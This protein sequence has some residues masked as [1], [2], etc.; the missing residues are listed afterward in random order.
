MAFAAGRRKRE[1]GLERVGATSLA[2][3]ASLLFYLARRELARRYAGSLLGPAWA[4]VFP[5]LQIALYWAVFRY[6]LRVETQGSVP[7]GPM[8][9]A[10]IVPWLA[11]SEALTTM[12]ASLKANASLVKRT[13]LPVE[14]LPLASLAAAACVHGAVLLLAACAL[15]LLGFAPGGHLLILVY[16]AP[17]V[18]LL[19]LSLGTLLALANVAFSD[20]AQA[21]A[22]ILLLWF[23]ATPIL[24]QTQMLPP[25]WRWLASANPLT[26]PVEL[27]RYALLGPRAG[28]P[29]FTSALSFWCFAALLAAAAW[30]A[31]RRFKREVADLL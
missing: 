31:L 14:L 4:L 12:T 13:A 16:A 9:I 29:D 28:V 27:Y 7:L 21:M 22:A 10:G 1:S 30:L 24:W 6:G 26:H 17:C 18:A 11:L 19:A 5:A 15:W 2:N 23:W 20:V 25:D 8:M 3:R